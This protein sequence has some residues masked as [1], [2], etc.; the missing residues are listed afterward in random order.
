MHRR[1]YCSELRQQWST[2]QQIIRSCLSSSCI[3]WCYWSAIRQAGNRAVW[4]AGDDGSELGC[5]YFIMNNS[6]QLRNRFFSP[7]ESTSPELA[8]PK[9]LNLQALICMNLPLLTSGNV[10]QSMLT[11]LGSMSMPVHSVTSD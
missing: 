8:C 7:I 6:L 5:L 11:V 10:I 1:N 2:C 9:G 3:W 4:A